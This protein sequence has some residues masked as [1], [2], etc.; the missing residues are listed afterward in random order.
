MPR[1]GR[2]RRP[3]VAAYTRGHP[4]VI[5][6]V[7]FLSPAWSWAAVGLL[8]T[9]VAV[10]AVRGVRLGVA[11][12]ALVIAGGACWA[13]AAG[14][15]VWDRPAARVVAVMVDLSPST[16]GATYRDRAALDRRVGQLLGAT[17]HELLAF[18]GGPPRPLPAGQALG[19]LPCD[20]TVFAP[21][22]AADAVVLFS[23]GRFE[24]PDVGPPTFAVV[25]PGLEAPA[26]AAVQRLQWAGDTVTATVSATGPQAVRWTGAEPATADATDGGVV[27]A[28]ATG[29]EVTAAVSPGDRWPENDRLTVHA[30]PPPTAERW[31]VGA[32][33]PP[34]GFRAVTLP[35]DPADYLAA[36]VVV[37]DDVSADGLSTL[38]QQRLAEAVRDLGTGLVIGGGRGAFAAGGYGRAPLDGLSPLASDPPGPAERW[39][40]LVDG[41]GSMAGP[42]WA[43]E[44]AAVTRVLAVL[45]AADA[46]RVG[47]FAAAVTWWPGDVPGSVHPTG[48]T[49]LAAALRAVADAGD[50]ATPTHLLLMTDAD[51]DLPDPAGLAAALRSHRVSLH[52][53]AIGDGSALA[54]LTDM[55]GATGGTV[56]R[57]VDPGQW[58]A[59]ARQLAR[60]VVPRRVVEQPTAVRWVVGNGPATVQPWNRTWAK[61]AAEVLA[62]GPDA[63]LVARRQAGAGRV[64]AVAFAADAGLLA[65]LAEGVA[66]EPRDPRFAVTWDAGPR[67]SVSVDAVDGTTYLNGLAVTLQLG[68]GPATTVGQSAPG[69]YEVAVP[70]P[71]EPTLAAVRV[72]GRVVD[73]FAVAG[74]YAAEFDV[75][76][77]D[78]AALAALAERTG[79]AV[80]EPSAAGP[81][82]FPGPPRRTWLASPLLTLG[83]AAVAAGLVRWRRQ[84]A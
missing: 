12:S 60:G 18:A 63:P 72:S 45:P 14:S 26:D 11:A 28:R 22:P 30:P 49:N 78:R 73:R 1:R 34:P 70:A 42:P 5:A 62:R 74:R 7:L 2:P 61:P 37:L 4:M 38:Q 80:V 8:A 52:L 16:R 64:T 24:L 41:S 75:V 39:V 3:A 21:P 40:V 79:G 27:S 10:A 51:A 77:N 54:A 76:G 82:T 66:A 84:R 29:A 9:A 83:A 36:G 44:C 58:V 68:D 56:V 53:L 20:R 55:A 43:T 35:T 65:A 67:L 69:R 33:P 81:L 19:D 23:D 47:S 17:P 48:P 6:A 32:A 15:P 71:R 59:A 25:D 50:P 31:W 57:Q 46:A 13:V